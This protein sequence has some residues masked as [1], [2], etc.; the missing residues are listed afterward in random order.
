MNETVGVVKTSSSSAN[1]ENIPSQPVKKYVTFGPYI[2]GST[3]GE[4]Q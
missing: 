4:G 3:L 2:I 1:I